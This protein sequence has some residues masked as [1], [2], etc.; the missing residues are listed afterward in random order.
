VNDPPPVVASERDDFR[1]W[2]VRTAE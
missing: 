1:N 2:F